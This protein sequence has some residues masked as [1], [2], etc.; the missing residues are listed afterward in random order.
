MFKWYCKLYEHSTVYCFAIFPNKK[1]LYLQR[2]RH[3]TCSR[4]EVCSAISTYI[5]K[6]K[7]ELFKTLIR[8]QSIRNAVDFLH[9]HKN[10][11]LNV[12]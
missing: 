5:G 8:N 7:L 4:F 2:K 6:Y 3:V 1:F 12:R 11:Q 9:H 10:S